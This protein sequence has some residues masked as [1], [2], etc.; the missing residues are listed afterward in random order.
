MFRRILQRVRQR[1]LPRRRRGRRAVPCLALPCRGMAGG[2]ASWC[3]PGSGPGSPRWGRS[4]RLAPAR[5]AAQ[6]RAEARGG[7][8]GRELVRRHE[9]RPES[10]RD[11]TGP[12]SRVLA[13]GGGFPRAGRGC[14]RRA[15]PRGPARG[16]SVGRG[17]ALSRRGSSP[18]R[19]GVSARRLRPW[20]GCRLPSLWGR[21]KG[22]PGWGER[23]AGAVS[24]QASWQRGSY[25]RK[26][27]RRPPATCLP[28]F[29]NRLF[30]QL[31]L[32]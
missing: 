8:G 3:R 13:G 27:A 31:W 17:A 10:R 2:A 20:R 16:L 4:R 12:R 25:R 7:R 26:P 9:T 22:S 30:R 11:R 14:R 1:D 15:C 32:V 28:Y 18:Q 21:L 24:R 29:R 5:F 23:G 19:R 6:G